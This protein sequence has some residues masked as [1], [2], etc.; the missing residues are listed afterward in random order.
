[1]NKLEELWKENPD[2]TVDDLLR[3]NVATD[4]VAQVAL[5]YQENVLFV[6][7]LYFGFTISE[8]SSR[9]QNYSEIIV[10]MISV[11]CNS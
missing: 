4:E 1:M 8:I 6:K 3:G 9:F 5:R 7:I 10:G 11:Y 2:A